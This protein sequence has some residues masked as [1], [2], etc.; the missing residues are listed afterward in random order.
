MGWAPRRWPAAR[1]MPAPSPSPGRPAS[2]AAWGSRAR[3]SS[4]TARSWRRST[5]RPSAAP[6]FDKMVAGA[7]AR[8]KALSTATYFEVDEVID[9]AD[10]RRWV[11]TAL[12]G[13]PPRPRNRAQEAAQ[14][15][16]V[17]IRERPL[18]GASYS[19]GR[20][21]RPPHDHE[22]AGRPRSESWKTRWR[23]PGERIAPEPVRRTRSPAAGP[24]SLVT[25]AGNDVVT[26]GDAVLLVVCLQG[27]QTIDPGPAGIVGP[28]HP[29][30]VARLDRDRSRCLQRRRSSAAHL[31]HFG[32]VERDAEF[33]A[34][35]ARA[36]P[37]VATV[38]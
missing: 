35:I 29:G 13:A 3:S 11:A 28:V 19:D 33:V 10:S 16:H 21:S 15:R 23:A 20:A 32:K 17:V 8:G 1:S 27:R 34:E 5:I 37:P 7:Y 12:L 36:D 14:H 4:A 6:L 9:P 18:R 26:H 2:S 31:A 30:P 24:S 22:R 38:V 25:Q